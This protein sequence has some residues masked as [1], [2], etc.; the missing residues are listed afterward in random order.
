ME[1]NVGYVQ[2]SAA[3]REGAR[4]LAER[5]VLKAR[6]LI[7][8]DPVVKTERAGRKAHRMEIVEFD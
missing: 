2:R 1:R 8:H 5:T 3:L 7:G 4:A 6:D